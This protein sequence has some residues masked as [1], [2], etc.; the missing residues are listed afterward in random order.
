VVFANVL[1]HLITVW[2]AKQAVGLPGILTDV[3]KLSQCNPSF[4]QYTVIYIVCEAR[5]R[6]DCWTWRV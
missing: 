4:L 2:N 1:L 5:C 3:T 6:G